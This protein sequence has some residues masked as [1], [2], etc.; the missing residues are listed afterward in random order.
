M[1][2]YANLDP[3]HRP[4]GL[5]TV[6]RWGILDRLTGA[7]QVSPPGPGAPWVTPDLELIRSRSEA[8]KLTWIGH[9]SFLGSLGGARFL[10]DPVFS[11]RVGAFYC[12]HVPPGLRVRDLPPIDLLLITHSH[13]DHLDAPSI[14]RLDRTT[15]VVV[16]AGLGRWF[17]RRDFTRV[18]ELDWWHST[19]VGQTGGL[20][21]TLTP[22]RHW[23][24]R[25]PWDG[26][27]SHWGGYVIEAGGTAVYNAGDSAWF[28]GFR[29]I[30]RRFPGLEVAMLPIGAYRPAWFMEHNHMNPEQAGRAFLEV[31]ARHFVPMHWG[32]FQ[33][34]DEPLTEPAERI[35]S[36]W[37][38]HR[39]SQA[40]QASPLRNKK[41]HLPAVGE[42]LVLQVGA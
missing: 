17:S 33:L 31:G 20:K 21:V 7:R 9:A 2:T 4:H 22:A 40:K 24:R 15:P 5:K 30:G 38:A 34:T 10:I 37:Q 14:S 18:T 41:M 19:E 29:E 16:P 12:R 28:D 13:P 42:T 6:V 35:R 23:S 32:T 27:R 3:T 36:W 25:T 39:P 11:R 26:N 1:T 8:P